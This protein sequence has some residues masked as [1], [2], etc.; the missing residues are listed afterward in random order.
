[1]K[2]LK[3]NISL[4]T[5][6]LYA[7]FIAMFRP[8]ILQPNVQ[9]V[10]RIAFLGLT[11][12]YI[13]LTTNIREY[14]NVA[15]PLSLCVF[16]S[17]FINYKDGLLNYSNFLNGTLRAMCIY[18]LYIMF[19]KVVKQK[20]AHAL[21]VYLH[22]L[23]SLYAIISVIS[24]F[25]VVRDQN[26]LY[27]FGSKYTTTYLLIF[28]SGVTFCL[29]EDRIKQSLYYKIKYLFI[30]LIVGLSIAYT[31][32]VTGV[33]TY[34]AFFV[35]SF[36]GDQI[37][38]I[39]T[40][41][42][43]VVLCMIGA[44]LLL[45]SLQAVLQNELVKDIIINILHKD[46]TLTDRLRYYNRAAFVIQNGNLFWG[47]GYAS[48]LMRSNIGLGTN[49]QNGLL[50]MIAEYGGVTVIV[51][52]ISTFYLTRNNFKT[53]YWGMYMALYTFIIASIVEV[54]YQLVFYSI[55]F[56]VHLLQKEETAGYYGIGV[57]SYSTKRRHFSVRWKSI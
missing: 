5:I 55:L 8:E 35:L 24:I 28:Y 49:L 4:T 16:L 27:F 33:V 19:S 57:T 46:L 25:W 30:Y 38:R 23:L 40:K 10:F 21:L 41:P 56:L 22:R 9:V 17:S 7:M 44:L 13:L 15:L 3:I 42:H 39:L 50:H 29:Y 31:G 37:K 36:A 45:L 14:W 51:L 6:M 1:M 52:L 53:A 26:G 32:C 43:V 54:S 20:G 18:C 2:S 48:E 12:I 11:L 34:A 47:Y